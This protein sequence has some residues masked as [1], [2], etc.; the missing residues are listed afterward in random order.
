MGLESY[1]N[2]LDQNL[3]VCEKALINDSRYD[4]A[5]IVSNINFCIKVDYLIYCACNYKHIKLE[6]CDIIQIVKVNKWI[7]L[8][9]EDS[10]SKTQSEERRFKPFSNWGGTNWLVTKAKERAPIW[11]IH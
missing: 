2:F 9:K 11:G 1:N 4:L 7:A 3:L 6:V 5:F 10:S 8:I